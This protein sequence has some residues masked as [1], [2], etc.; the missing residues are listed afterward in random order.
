[1]LS[2]KVYP[3]GTVTTG[4]IRKFKP[5]PVAAGNFR[6]LKSGKQDFRYLKT[7]TEDQGDPQNGSNLGLSNVSNSA[8]DLSHRPRTPRGRGGITSHGRRLV[9][10]GATWLQKQVGR[11]CL[12]FLTCTLPAL[13]LE[14][15]LILLENWSRLMANFKRR[16][17]YHL[18]KAGLPGQIIGVTEVQER[19]AEDGGGV[20]LHIHWVFQG[21]LPRNTWSLKPGFVAALWRECCGEII[22]TLRVDEWNASVRI[23]RI[24]K[25]TSAYMSKYMSK[26]SKITKKLIEN[27]WE[28][29]LPSAWYV[30]TEGIKSTY[31]KNLYVVTGDQA[32]FL[33][34]ICREC[35]SDLFSF[36]KDIYID[37]PNDSQLYVGWVAK[38]I[39]SVSPE[40][41]LS[42][43]LCVRDS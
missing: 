43:Y 40:T 42:T 36:Q 18:R 30:C 17:V 31:K 25:D 8:K 6:Y 20:P 1:L 11:S 22:G 24:L 5:E 14:E 34:R 37:L 2:L 32:V 4:L 10:F 16:L 26:G 9:R 41:F 19:R 13:P 29:L 21:R 33:S 12:S 23:E 38:L 15:L 27:G 28:W 35:F 7:R 3:E 39:S